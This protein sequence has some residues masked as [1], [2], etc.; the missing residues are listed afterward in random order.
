MEGSKILLI[1]RNSKNEKVKEDNLEEKLNDAEFAADF[2]KELIELD[3]AGLDIPPL[4]D[5][6][7]IFELFEAVKDEFS[8]QWH[9]WEWM[10][11]T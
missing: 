10:R 6:Y 3:Y 1:R 9:P 5:D 7:P 4:E 11:S 8:I 2:E